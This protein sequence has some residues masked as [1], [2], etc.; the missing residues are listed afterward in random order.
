MPVTLDKNKA[1]LAH[2]P[3]TQDDASLTQRI[4]GVRSIDR[5]ASGLESEQ[6]EA[7]CFTVHARDATLPG[8][9]LISV[10]S[11][12]ADAFLLLS[13]IYLSIVH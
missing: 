2:F 5:D 6:E 13:A 1:S 10:I 4:H 9:Q 3:C 11:R 12:D 7:D 8:S